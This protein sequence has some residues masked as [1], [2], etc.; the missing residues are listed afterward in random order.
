[1]ANTCTDQP[2][3]VRET[4]LARSRRGEGEACEMAITGLMGEE[5][6]AALSSDAEKEEREQPFRI[7]KMIPGKRRGGEK[8]KQQSGLT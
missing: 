1:M 5:C 2:T 7:Q 4:L 8:P 6:Y 3:N